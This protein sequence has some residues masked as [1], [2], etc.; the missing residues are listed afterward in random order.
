MAKFRK[1]P[2]VVEAVQLNDPKQKIDGVCNSCW[3]LN[4]V[5]HIHTLNG[6]KK[7]PIGDWIITEISGEKYSCK[8]DIFEKTY[9][10][11]KEEKLSKPE[12]DKCPY[13]GH[14]EDFEW[15]SYGRE[16]YCNGC[17]KRVI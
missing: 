9:E 7:I 8:P 15:H 2:V 4:N 12:V 6:I 14:I 13:Y 5:P 11:V 17:G 3:E 16:A 10:N 1:K